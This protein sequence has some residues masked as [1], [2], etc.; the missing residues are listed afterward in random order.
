MNLLQSFESFVKTEN[1]FQQSDKLIIAV[2]GGVDSVVLCE[3]CHR[4]GFDFA[5]AHCNFQLRGEESRRDEQFVRSISEKYGAGFF[6][7][8]FDTEKYALKNRIGIQ[9]AARKLRYDWFNTIIGQWPAPGN[10]KS[11][12][13]NPQST[14]SGRTF[15]LTAHHANDNIETLLMNFFR[16]TGIA[17]LKGILPRQGNVIRPLL[18]ATKQE[19]VNFARENNLS[20]EEDSSNVS[21]KY[22]RNYFRNQLIPSIQK[23]Y[24]GVADNLK[25]NLE[26]FREIDLLYQQA[27]DSLK[28]KLLEPKGNEI[29]LPVLKLMRS[30]PLYTIVYEIIREFNFTSH[31][32]DEVIGLLSSKSG[33]YLQ[34]SSHKIIRNRG[35]LIIAPN[36][37]VSAQNI[38]IEEKDKSVLFSQG[39]LRIERRS[40]LNYQVL[41][42]SSVA[43]L[44]AD[45]IRFPLLMRKWK[46]GDYFYPLGM[47]KKKKLSR[48]FIDQKMSIQDKENTWIIE[49]DKKILWIVGRRID[50]RF[51]I[52][53][54]TK[55]LLV[56]NRL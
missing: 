5:I 11:E 21:D 6:V 20:F 24:P 9:E 22:T 1:L 23:V 25:N 2:S 42:D 4:S 45:E 8:K 10:P 36:D 27:I 30:K 51:K 43:A 16:G 7:K 56:F 33:K 31:Q 12:I 17:G 55:T 40:A 35:W 47:T 37:T 44:D 28:K 13:R 14:H 3:L 38:L 29:H 48:F 15:L 34:S 54:K 39:Q 19:I 49:M 50:N 41:P 26:R 53:P 18:F 52:T 46:Q 32:T